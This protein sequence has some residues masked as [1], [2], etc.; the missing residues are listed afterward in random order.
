M[1]ESPENP[2]GEYV[3]VARIVRPQGRQGEVTAEILT[4]FP[5]RFTSMRAAF[6]EQPG[7]PPAA[8]QVENAWPHKGRI[9]L[10][11]AGVDSITHAEGLRGRHVLVRR[12]DRV[13]VG[14]NRYYFQDLEGCRVAV[15]REGRLIEVGKVTGVEPTGGVDL[16]RVETP[17]GEVL[18]PLA[19]DICKRIDTDSKTIVIDPP[20]DL[21]DLNLES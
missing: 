12:A 4:D 18:V 17:Q 1:L 21:L 10:K 16:L 15:E 20:E 11:F 19:Q 5:E 9:I 6:L 3:A 14:A 2:D 7:R 13:P 8:V